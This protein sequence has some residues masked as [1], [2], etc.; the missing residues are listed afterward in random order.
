MRWS[1]RLERRRRG[2]RSRSCASR[3]TPTGAG[4]PAAAR[5]GS[6]PGPAAG[7]SAPAARSRSARTR[8]RRSTRELEEEWAVVPE[9]LAVEAL[10]SLDTGLVMLIGQA[11]LPRGRRGRARPRARRARLVAAGPDAW[12]DEADPRAAADGRPSLRDHLHTLK[13]LSFTHSAIYLSLLTVW[14]GRRPGG[15]EEGARLG[16]RHRLDRDVAAVHRRRARCA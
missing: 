3:A 1:L 15:A 9:R 10:V 6:R 16:A 11:W 4:W 12:P 2:A 14:L 13:Y 5:R 7:R 8:W